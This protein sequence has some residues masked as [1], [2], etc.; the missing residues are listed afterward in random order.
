M[1]VES[2]KIVGGF[3]W[4]TLVKYSNDIL[5]FLTTLLLAK[6][7]V[8][9]DFGLVAVAGMVIEALRIFK[10][11][12]LSQALIYRQ[13]DV[14]RASHTMFIMVIALNVVV[15][16]CAVLISPLAGRFFNNP[17]VVPIIAIMASNLI[18]TSIRAVPDALMNKELSFKKL[19]VPDIIP[20]GIGSIVSIAM[21][22]QGFGVWS[23][24]VRSL[25]ISIGGMILIWPYTSYRPAFQFDRAVARELMNYGKHIVGSSVVMVA[26]Y[27][28]D[29]FFISKFVGVAAL[30]LYTMAVHIANLPINQFAHIVCR[31][32][33]P[34]FSKMNRES[35]V[36][37]H[38][39]LQT[40]RYTT[41]VTFP[42][43][44]GIAIYGP[45]AIDAFYGDKWSA[46][47]LPLQILTGY[48][49]CR[50]LSVIIYEMFKATGRPD[51]MQ[52]FVL[53]RLA[54]IGLL[55]IPALLWLGLPGICWLIT[56][57][58]AIV[59][60]LEVKKVAADLKISGG[61]FMRALGLPVLLSASLIPAVYW[62]VLVGFGSMGLFQVIG[63]IVV[64][65][66]LYSAAV[67]LLDRVLVAEAK[68]VLFSTA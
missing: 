43:A 29:K 7:L 44:I 21:A 59:L 18:W 60:A 52:F 22:Y 47:G 66:A 61:E 12:G 32:M 16:L 58:Y 39:F 5:G 1:A 56:G 8:P 33:F 63:G 46:V 34:V 41:C 55:G 4:I 9:E 68:K 2:K 28:V 50:S 10:D 14:E 31:L 11:L 27:N 23:L 20:V 64:T 30:G 62:A 3:G 48:A 53:V 67:V 36:L 35:E 45:D 26:V 40:I 19:V 37:K 6:L 15:F 42:M 17:G 65:G 54:L 57:T 24:V 51:L 49:L 13:D 25:I 38:S